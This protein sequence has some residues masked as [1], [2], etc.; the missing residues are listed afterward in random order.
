M[1]L[2]FNKQIRD[3]IAAR[4]QLRVAKHYAR[5]GNVPDIGKVIEQEMDACF[6]AVIEVL[7]DLAKAVEIGSRPAERTN[8]GSDQD[9]EDS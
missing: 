7:T 3:I 6:G 4:V 5:Y 1:G 2:D 9:A 8:A